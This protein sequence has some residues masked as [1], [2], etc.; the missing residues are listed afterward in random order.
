MSSTVLSERCPAVT[1]TLILL[2]VA[3]ARNADGVLAGG[4]LEDHRGLAGL[5][6]PVDGDRRTLGLGDQVQLAG[7]L[8]LQLGQARLHLTELLVAELARVGAGDELFECSRGVLALAL[9]VE[10]HRDPVLGVGGRQDLVGLLEAVDGFGVVA[11]A[12]RLLTLAVG[13]AGGV[14]GLLVGALFGPCGR[15]ALGKGQGQ[16]ARARE[17]PCHHQRQNLGKP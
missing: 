16:R 11:G 8:A 5:R 12:V 10:R 13:L 15:L 3:G 1:S 4:E 14:S 17:R 9:L 2:L 7:L 6:L